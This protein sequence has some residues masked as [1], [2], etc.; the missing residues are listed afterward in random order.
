[1]KGGRTSPVS[2]DRDATGGGRSMTST[3]SLRSRRRRVAL[4]DQHAPHM[5]GFPDSHVSGKLVSR[6]PDRFV[7]SIEQRPT[8]RA[9]GPLGH[10][11]PIAWARADGAL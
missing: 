2:N 3:C 9:A 5:N 7:P 11:R 4:A 8:H 10:V 1:M 6:L